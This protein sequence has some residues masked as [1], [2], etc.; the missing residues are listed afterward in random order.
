MLFTK[1]VKFPNIFNVDVGN[2]DLDDQY[3][4]INRCLALLLTTA[5][6]ELLGDPDFGCTLYERLFDPY[7]ESMKETIIKEII[8]SINKYEKRISVTD[9][10]INI[11]QHNED[12]LSYTIHIK[13]KL[14]NSDLSNT[15]FIYISEEDRNNRG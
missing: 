8:D 6:G 4:S 7:V 9:T 12:R 15:T 2:T 1:S 14:K 5:K 3:A 13:Y 10:D 11:E